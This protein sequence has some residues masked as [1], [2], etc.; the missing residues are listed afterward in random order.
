MSERIYTTVDVSKV[1]KVSLRTVIRWV[2]EGKLPSFRTPGGHRRVRENDLQAFLDRYKIPFSVTLARPAKRILVVEERKTLEGL[3]KQILRRASDQF[4]I[5]SVRDLYEGA[6]QVGLLSPDLVIVAGSPKSP[7]I[8]KFCR[9]LR[10]QAKTSNAKILVLSSNPS[11]LKQPSLRSL[12]V[13]AIVKKP[14]SAED[15]RPQLLRLLGTSAPR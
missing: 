4:E 6:R 7:E 3:L 12:G 9:A 5:C 8:L 13:Q 14:V 10:K 11:S 2:D 15:L 1:C